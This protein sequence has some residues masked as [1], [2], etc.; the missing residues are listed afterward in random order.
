MISKEKFVKIL[1][2]LKET[3]DLQNQINELFMRARDNIENDFCNAGSFMISHEDVVV[4]LLEEIFGD[5]GE[6]PNTSWWI[7][8]TDYG[9]NKKMNKI[10]EEDAKTVYKELNTAEDLYD[11]LL[12]NYKKRCKNE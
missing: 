9:R 5:S 3:T 2:R 1:N 10:Y 6:Y 7:Y 4:D 8:E 12:E 11:Y